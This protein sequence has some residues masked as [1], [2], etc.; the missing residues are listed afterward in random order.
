[1]CPVCVREL[2]DGFVLAALRVI[3]KLQRK[4][5]LPMTAFQAVP[6][7]DQ[8]APGMLNQMALPTINERIRC[9]HRRAGF[10]L[11]FAGIDISWNEYSPP[12]N[13][14]FWQGQVY[15]V[16]IGLDVEAVKSA[17]KSSYPHHASISKPLR[18]RECTDLPEALSYAIKPAFVRRVATSI[19][20]QAGIT[21]PI[22]TLTRL[23][24]GKWH[25]ASGD[26]SC[27]SDT[28]SLVAV[29]IGTG[30]T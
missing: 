16:V 18:V 6:L 28:L 10:S 9:R 14:P 24:S 15:G 29:D 13:P 30:S 11:V 20:A 19:L 8:Y 25:C 7:Q 26:T 27:R 1:M 21:L 2:R 23:S 5:I 4:L 3:Q 17:L 12:R 22:T